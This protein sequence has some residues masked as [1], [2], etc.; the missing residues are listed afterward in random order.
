MTNYKLKINNN[1]KLKINNNY[2]LKINKNMK[3]MKNISKIFTLSVV[4]LLLAGNL[5]AQDLRFS[6]PFANPLKYNPAS[7]G[8]NPDLKF[9]LHYRSQWSVLDKGYST[10]AFTTLYPIYIKDGKEKLDVG[11]NILQDQSGAFKS[12]D[13]SL[14]VGYNLQISNSG[15]INFSLLGGYVQKSLSTADLTFD[16]QYVTGTYSAS[17]ANGEVILNEKVGYPDV[18][19]GAMWYYNPT[20]DDDAKLNAYLGAAV[21]HLNTPNESLTGTPNSAASEGKLPMRFSYQG[22]IKILG[23]DKIDFTPNIIV[24][25]QEGAENTA[26]GLYTG[27]HFSEKSKAVLGVWYRKKDAIALHLGFEH[28]SFTIGYSYDAVTSEIRNYV[29]TNAHEIS[30]CYRINMSEKKGA[31]ANPSFFR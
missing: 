5:S 21:F 6:Q 28:T 2:K 12:L 3:N 7:M 29:G 1:Y 13:A 15:N 8:I 4:S 27:Y 11:V 19:F 17:N 24:T 9:I 30:L 10:Y 25:T 14:A 20:K 16:N 22:G 26:A 18:G 23:G 31:K